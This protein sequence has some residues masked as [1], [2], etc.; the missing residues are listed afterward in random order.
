LRRFGKYSNWTYLSII[1]I[2][3]IVTTQV[4]LFSTNGSQN[5]LIQWNSTIELADTTL[6]ESPPALSSAAMAYDVESDRVVLFGGFSDAFGISDETWSY[7]FNTNTWTNMAP[8]N[9][10]PALYDH[11][12]VYNTHFDLIILYGG[13]YRYGL[14]EYV[15]N[16]TWTYDLNS[17]TWTEMFPAICPGYCDTHSM[18]YDSRQDLVILFSGLEGRTW[19]YDVNQN[20][21]VDVSQEGSPSN[22]EE[23]KMV[24][25]DLFDISI[26][27]G[28]SFNF[29]ILNDTWV[30]D[31]DFITWTNV[32]PTTAPSTN[33]SFSMIYDIHANRA[34]VFGAAGETWT[35]DRGTNTWYEMNPKV[36]PSARGESCMA[37][38]SES[39]RTI[40]FSGDNGI[41]DTW[42]YSYD[43]NTWTNMREVSDDNTFCFIAYGDTRGD[44]GESVSH[45]HDD[46]VGLYVQH[47][48]EFVIHTGDMVR[49]GAQLY[50]WSDFNDSI[51][52]LRALDIPIYGTPGNHEVYT[53]DE[54]PPDE[55][56]INYQNFFD[57]SGVIDQ[58]GETEL[59]YSFDA[60]G[61]HF[62][63]LDTVHG[64]GNDTYTCPT[65]QMEWL[66][67]DLAANY[68]FIIIS[69]HYPAWSVLS[70]R[71]DRWAVAECIRNAFHSI[72]VEHG[73]DIVFNGHDH[74][75]YHTI[76]DGIH[77]VV[78]GGGGAPIA[79][80][81]MGDTVWQAHDKGFSDYHYCVAT[82]ENG[83]LNVEVFLLDGAVADSFSLDLP[84]PTIPPVIIQGISIISSVALVVVATA[85]VWI[86]IK[87][88]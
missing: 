75:Y 16:A 24:Y 73:V 57:Y 45:I 41:A 29:E 76:R 72:F 59:H 50:Q 7:D 36:S 80:I 70:H 79:Q 25:D 66:E 82:A 78:T 63:F 69:F 22:R 31:I 55:D 23:S 48:P 85:V 20:H 19:I 17:N 37:F 14:D 61:I 74:Y 13:R 15:S 56:L 64:W 12:M 65:A 46:I 42:A 77:Y 28:G 32:H 18:T 33:S 8:E 53:E 68:K 71:P 54:T 60:N 11:E 34:I 47:D 44:W 58:P 1:C 5:Q 84:L 9:S 87:K 52:T 88:E 39:H 3:L 62:V 35:Y 30:Y 81:Q 43:E 40:L 67:N 6:S 21:W 10:P 83:V 27:Y 86:K 51:S 2:F 49:Q 38:D 4:G 26:L